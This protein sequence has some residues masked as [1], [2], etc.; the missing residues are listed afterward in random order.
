[1]NEKDV[2]IW[3]NFYKYGCK[4]NSLFLDTLVKSY[5]CNFKE[6][7]YIQQLFKNFSCFTH[8]TAKSAITK[9]VSFSH[10]T[11]IPYETTQ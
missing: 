5:F 10:I 2:H 3:L 11:L 7:T 8:N 4:C 1:M 9:Y 6:I